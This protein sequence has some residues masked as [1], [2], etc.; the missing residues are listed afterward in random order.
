M[1]NRTASGAVAS[2]GSPALAGQ[3][4]A[5]AQL[6]GQPLRSSARRMPTN[7]RQ[8]SKCVDRQGTRKRPPRPQDTTQAD[9]RTLVCYV[10]VLAIALYL[11]T[12]LALGL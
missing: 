1:Q 5:D 7:T 9:G 3:R 12:K 10:G 2:S 4:A 8:N 11:V 6:R